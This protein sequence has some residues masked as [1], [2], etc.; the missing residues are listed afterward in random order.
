MKVKVKCRRT[1]YYD[2]EV[3]LNEDDIKYIKTYYGKVNN[4][5]IENYLMNEYPLD[6][7]LSV[8]NEDFDFNIEVFNIKVE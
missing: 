6:N 1:I 5:T 2:D 8:V 3:V 7:Y 4:D